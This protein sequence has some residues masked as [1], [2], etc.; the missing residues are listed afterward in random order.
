[1]TPSVSAL[2]ST[3]RLAS[4]EEAPAEPSGSVSVR[5]EFSVCALP[6]SRKTCTTPSG[7]FVAPDFV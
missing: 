1:M 4:D 2:S 5:G 7:R 3:I 6:V